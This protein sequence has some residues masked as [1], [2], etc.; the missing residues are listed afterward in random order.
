[1]KLGRNDLH[2]QYNEDLVNHA[3]KNLALVI[4]AK[5]KE[6]FVEAGQIVTIHHGFYHWINAHNLPDG[7]MLAPL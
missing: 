7:Q 6:I 2:Y 1:M 4:D 3:A 5:R